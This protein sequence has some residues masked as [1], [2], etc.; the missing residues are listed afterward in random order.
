VVQPGST[1]LD[2]GVAIVAEVHRM[3]ALNFVPAQR[4]AV[5]EA[6]AMV[7]I[8]IAAATAPLDCIRKDV[9]VHGSKYRC[10]RSEPGSVRVSPRAASAQ[11]ASHTFTAAHCAYGAEEP[12]T[13]MPAM[14]VSQ[15]CKCAAWKMMHQRMRLLLA[16]APVRL[17]VEVPHLPWSGLEIL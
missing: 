17:R 8:H 1:P 16:P 3:E 12:T 5:I 6:T 11:L 13:R 9:I 7:N 15:W 10:N 14:N 2:E 4:L